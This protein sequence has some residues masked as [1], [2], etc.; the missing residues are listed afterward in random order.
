MLKKFILENKYD[1]IYHIVQQF[2]MLLF[3]ASF[4]ALI[5]IFITFRVI[6]VWVLIICLASF[7]IALFIGLKWLLRDFLIFKDAYIEVNKK[8]EGSKSEK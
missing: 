7:F 5:P 4:T 2:F 6:F 3:L 8:R 1:D